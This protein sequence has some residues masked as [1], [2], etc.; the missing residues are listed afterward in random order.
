VDNRT[1]LAIGITTGLV[2]LAAV[3]V[4]RAGQVGSREVN[5]PVADQARAVAVQ[6]VSGGTADWVDA[7]PDGSTSAFEVLVTKPDS[8][9]FAVD[10]NQTFEV[11][12]TQVTSWDQDGDIVWPPDL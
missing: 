6:A 7:E 8:T 3:G 2:V 4:S 11:L 10:L 9:A 1:T 12:D 5:G